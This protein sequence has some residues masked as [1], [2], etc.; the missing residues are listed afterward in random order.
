MFYFHFL[1]LGSVKFPFPDS[2][3]KIQE[4]KSKPPWV[5][6]L[7]DSGLSPRHLLQGFGLNGL[8]WPRY[9]PLGFKDPQRFQGANEAERH[10]SNLDVCQLHKAPEDTTIN[11]VPETAPT[12]GAV[13]R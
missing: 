2:F 11:D 10:C 13:R 1:K 5:V 8:R 4:A 6:H 7:N 3:E 9:R 12:R